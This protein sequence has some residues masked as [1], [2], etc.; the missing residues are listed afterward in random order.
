MCWPGLL[1]PSRIGNKHRTDRVVENK[2]GQKVLVVVSK[3]EGRKGG[4]WSTP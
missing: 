3:G 4:K 2:T 1:P